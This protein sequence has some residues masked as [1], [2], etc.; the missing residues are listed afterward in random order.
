MGSATTIAISPDLQFVASN[1]DV[2][3]MLHVALGDPIAVGD[4]TLQEI[5]LGPAVGGF[6]YLWPGLVIIA[7]LG[8][9]AVVG[10]PAVK[11]HTK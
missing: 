4:A 5:G 11:R 2:S 7:L 6:A 10:T 1:A 9:S 8:A 3:S